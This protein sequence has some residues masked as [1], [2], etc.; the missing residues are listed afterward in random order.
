MSR[1]KRRQLT[2][3]NWRGEFPIVFL[4]GSWVTIGD[5]RQCERPEVGTLYF[6]A[7][8]IEPPKPSYL[9]VVTRGAQ[10]PIGQYASAAERRALLSGERF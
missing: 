7:L 5:W 6:C 9:D 10:A 8:A 3:G 4:G 1:A 2:I